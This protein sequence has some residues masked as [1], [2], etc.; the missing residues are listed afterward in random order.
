MSILHTKGLKKLESPELSELPELILTSE[1]GRIFP[2]INQ[3]ISEMFET[4]VFRVDIN[5]QKELIWA[6]SFQQVLDNIG[7]IRRDSLKVA[8]DVPHLI[9][10]AAFRQ[11]IF[12]DG[13]T[14]KGKNDNIVAPDFS[15]IIESDP[16]YVD[17]ISHQDDIIKQEFLSLEVY[18]KIFTESISIYEKNIKFKSSDLISSGISPAELQEEIVK[19][20][21]QKDYIGKFEEKFEVGLFCQFCRDMKNMFAKSPVDCLN[22]IKAA[23]PTITR[24]LLDVFSERVRTARDAL[25]VPIEDVPSFV[26]FILSAQ[27]YTT[28]QQRFLFTCY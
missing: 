15:N 1:F 27:K 14:E 21:E 19:Y 23:L 10:H 3:R 16:V 7:Q 28:E 6:P 8:Y 22:G 12:P 13:V 4:P 25:Y 2:S 20:N 11:Y 18:S 5:F 17:I 9:H 26:A 24:N